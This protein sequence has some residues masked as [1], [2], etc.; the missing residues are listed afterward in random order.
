MTEVALVRSVLRKWYD[1]RSQRC[2]LWH[3]GMNRIFETDSH[4]VK[5]HSWGS[6]EKAALKARE[7]LLAKIAAADCLA[8][9]PIRNSY[10][11]YYTEHISV[12]GRTV[13]SVYNRVACD[14]QPRSFSD[15]SSV[16]RSFRRVPKGAHPAA[17]DSGLVLQAYRQHLSGTQT[18]ASPTAERMIEGIS[19]TL[20]R[21]ENRCL[22]HGD[23]HLYNF[24]IETSGQWIAIDCDTFGFG[25]YLYDVATLFWSF[26]RRRF[27]Y[28]VSR[29]AREIADQEETISVLG[30]EFGEALSG[31]DRHLTLWNLIIARHI[32]WLGLRAGLAVERGRELIFTA[33]HKREVVLLEQLEQAALQS[34][35]EGDLAQ[36]IL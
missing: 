25:H 10:G 2:L 27:D 6:W 35:A 23:L 9:L 30:A 12:S 28:D 5:L 22:L 20:D 15:V 31:C 21:S 17:I 36:E 24:G 16:V 29:L 1:I 4:V 18:P 33:E 14:V 32:W 19:P 11:S 7:E 8:L 34:T 13:F 3:K 26:L